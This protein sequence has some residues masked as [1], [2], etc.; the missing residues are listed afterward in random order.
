MLEISCVIN[1]GVH[2][3]RVPIYERNPGSF[4]ACTAARRLHMNPVGVEAD[5]AAEDSSLL[6]LHRK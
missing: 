2:S 1:L 3:S 5:M 6:P 4:L